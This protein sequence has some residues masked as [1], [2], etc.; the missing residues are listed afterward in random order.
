MISGMFG[1]NVALPM[2]QNPYAFL[3]LLM[4][5]LVMGTVIVR[6]FKKKKWF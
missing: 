2:E 6:V 4:I 3:I 1:M 5:M